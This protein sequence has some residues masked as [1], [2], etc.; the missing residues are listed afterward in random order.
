MQPTHTKGRVWA[1]HQ[2]K[3]AVIDACWPRETAIKDLHPEKYLVRPPPGGCPLTGRLGG[4]VVLGWPNARPEKNTPCK[5]HK[6][7]PNTLALLLAMCALFTMLRRPLSLSAGTRPPDV[8]HD[9]FTSEVPCSAPSRG[10]PVRV[11]SAGLAPASCASICVCLSPSS[12]DFLAQ[13]YGNCTPCIPPNAED[14]VFQGY[15]RTK[16]CL[17]SLVAAAGLASCVTHPTPSSRRCQPTCLARVLFLS[18]SSSSSNHPSGTTGV[19]LL[20]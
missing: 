8:K 1:G 15:H 7:S 2:R 6:M 13:P 14:Q 3:G 9:I 16:K 4:C 5:G 12:L 19:R 20:A 18:S 11:S 10:P 17:S